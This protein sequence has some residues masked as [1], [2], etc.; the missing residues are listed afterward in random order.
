VLTDGEYFRLTAKIF[1]LG[2]RQTGLWQRALDRYGPEAGFVHCSEGARQS[3]L[4]MQI[5][6]YVMYNH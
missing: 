2:F 6:E 3:D 1:D 5:S 4:T